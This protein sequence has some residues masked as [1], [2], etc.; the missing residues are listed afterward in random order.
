MGPHSAVQNVAAMM[1]ARV[2]S[3]VLLPYSQGSTMLLLT[4]SSTNT[5]ASVHISMSQPGATAN[6]RASGNTAATSGPT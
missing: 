3:P 6:A 1:M 2:D 4:S 5:S